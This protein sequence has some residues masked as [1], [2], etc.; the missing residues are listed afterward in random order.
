M[1]LGSGWSFHRQGNPETGEGWYGT[2]VNA[3]GGIALS[4]GASDVE[5]SIYIILMTAKGE[6]VMRPN[7][8]CRIHE[9]VFMPNDASTHGL[10][11][12]YI[13]EALGW[14]EPRIT[15]NQIDIE[16]DKY[17]PGRLFIK[18]MY[19]IKTTNDPRNL[20]FPF[21]IIPGE[22]LPELQRPEPAPLPQRRIQ[23]PANRNQQ[24]RR[25]QNTNTNGRVRPRP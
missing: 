8:G 15:V 9:L 11:D 24:A 12:L 6:R 19:T 1:F 4:T 3:R 2:G 10:I 23:G 16:Q 20:V 25:G 22:E 18:I 5:E 13:R 21:Y 17:D 14:Y 7:F